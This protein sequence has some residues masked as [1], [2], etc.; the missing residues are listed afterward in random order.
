MMLDDGM[1]GPMEE[2]YD[3][4]DDDEDE[5]MGGPGPV[6]ATNSPGQPAPEA[7]NYKSKPRRKSSQRPEVRALHGFAPAWGPRLL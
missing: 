5:M 2:E 6:V 3:D 7:V 4:D 1:A